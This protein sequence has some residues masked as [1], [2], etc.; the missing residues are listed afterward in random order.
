MKKRFFKRVKATSP[1]I[2][3]FLTDPRMLVV[4]VSI[5]LWIF[6]GFASVD[7]FHNLQRKKQLETA[8]K[9]LQND[10]Q[11]WQEMAVKYPNSR[12]IY[13][14]LAVLEYQLG[15]KAKAKEYLQKTLML[16]PNFKE[17]RSMEKILLE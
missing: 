16:D 2:Y 12:D 9:Q 14:R 7:I 17:A 10:I 4:V 15:E 3:R 8:Q 5:V 11:H 13:F 6:I 1:S